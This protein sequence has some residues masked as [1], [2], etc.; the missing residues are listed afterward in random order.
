[1]RRHWRLI[2]LALSV[3]VMC[4][5]EDTTF[6]SSVPAYPV[7]ISIDTRIGQFVHFQPTDLN[8]NIVVNKGGY[9]FNGNYVLPFAATDACGY[10]GVVV[11]VSMN[12]YIAY[13]LACPH[14]ASK[15]LCR[16]CYIDGMYAVCPECS[17]EYDLTSGYAIPQHGIS[18]EAMRRLDIRDVG[19]KLTISQ[20][21]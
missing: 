15:Q 7:R 1:M 18:H 8:S 6:R 13:D 12:G 9:F 20:M 14:C 17:E 3:L 5:C 10:G 19:G 21:P 4:A 16:P 11:F 2:V